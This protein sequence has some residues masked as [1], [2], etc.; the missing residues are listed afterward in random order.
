MKHSNNIKKLFTLGAFILATGWTQT[1]C[2]FTYTNTDLLLV[3]REQGFFDV[4]FNIGS[5]SNFYTPAAQTFSID[6]NNDG[7]LQTPLGEIKKKGN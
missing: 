3:F 6:I 5:V 4:E 2:A 7:T 1:L